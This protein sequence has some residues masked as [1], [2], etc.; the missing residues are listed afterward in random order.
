[1][2]CWH[3]VMS[4]FCY[5]T[6]QV[7]TPHRLALLAKIDQVVGLTTVFKLS[8]LVLVQKGEPYMAI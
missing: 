4:Q 2:L 1:M 8:T 7:K 5:V 6:A 3:L